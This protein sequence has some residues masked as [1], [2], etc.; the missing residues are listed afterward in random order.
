MQNTEIK[1]TWTALYTRLSS[2]DGNLGVSMSIQSHDV[3]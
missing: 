3:I 1:D 2:D